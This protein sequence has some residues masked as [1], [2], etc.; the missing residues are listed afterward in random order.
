MI[1]N[2]KC[3]DDDDDN[4]K[5]DRRDDGLYVKMNRALESK[6]CFVQNGRFYLFLEQQRTKMQSVWKVSLHKRRRS[7]QSPVPVIFLRSVGT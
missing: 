2:S 7:S 1:H 3:Q 5:K 4:N 6:L